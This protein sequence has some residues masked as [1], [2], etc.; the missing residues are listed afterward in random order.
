[1]DFV[2][3]VSIFYFSIIFVIVSQIL[4][5]INQDVEIKEQEN[6]LA[7]NSNPVASTGGPILNCKFHWMNCIYEFEV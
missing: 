3:F 2:V 7:V 1:M 5:K 4:S 6:V